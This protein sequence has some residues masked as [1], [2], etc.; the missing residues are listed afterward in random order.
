MSVRIK[1]TSYPRLYSAG[2]YASVPIGSNSIPKNS[3]NN[4]VTS[5]T[6][7]K[8]LLDPLRAEIDP[9]MQALRTQEK[10]EIKGLNN[11]FASYI[12]KVRRSIPAVHA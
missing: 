11:R 3:T 7:N 9:A 1:G 8:S 12:E 2:S 5:V 6:F 10:D 4:Y